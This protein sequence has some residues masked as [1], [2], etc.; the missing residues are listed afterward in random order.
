MKKFVSLFVALAIVLSLFAGVGARTA[1]AAVTPGDVDS[2]GI[3]DMIDALL[4]ARAAVHITTL[5]GDAL[6]AADVNADGTVDMVDVLLI[7]RIAVTPVTTVTVTVGS[8]T[9]SLLV[10][11]TGTIVGTPVPADAAI[12]YASSDVAIATV[13]ATTGVVT[14][15]AAGTAT[16]TVTG[17]KT[18][19]TNGTATVAVTVAPAAVTLSTVSAVNGTVT[20]TLSGT[21]AIAPAIADFA[22]TQAINGAAATAVT[23]TAISTTGAVVTLTVPL[24]AVGAAGTVDQSVV[25]S[26]SYKSGTAVNASAFTVVSLF[27][28]SS[29]ST[30]GLTQVQIVFNRALDPTSAVLKTNY[31]YGVAGSE[32]ALAVGDT[33][34]LSADAK[35]VTLTLA[36]PELQQAIKSIKVLTTL[37]DA[38][39]TALAASVT[40]SVTFFDTTT[41]T[42]LSAEVSGPQSIKV[43][44]SEPITSSAITTTSNFVVDGGTY[45]VAS[46]AA[47]GTSAVIVSLGL[48]LPAG[49]HT[50]TVNN[51]GTN[52]NPAIKDYAGFF[53]PKTTLNFT[54]AAD[55]AAPTVSLVSAGQNSVIIEFSKPIVTNRSNLRVYHTYANASYLASTTTWDADNQTVTL[56]FTTY[57]P[58]G[59]A[60][61]FVQN[62]DTVAANQ[63]KDSWGNA[64]V[65]AT[66]TAT[67]TSDTTAPTVTSAAFNAVSGKIDVTFSEA[68]TATS[69]S[70][71]NDAL[72]PANYVLKLGTTTIAVTGVTY[73]A[74]VASLTA[75]L[76]GG[77]YT[78]VVKNVEDI[79][80]VPNIMVDSA[81][82][83][84]AVADT[85][86]PYT[87][88]ND[89]TTAGVLLYA[90]DGTSEV[91]KVYFSE[92]MNATDLADVTKYTATVG[93]V[94]GTNPDTAVAAADGKSVTLTFSGAATL[95]FIGQ[96]RDLSG[97]RMA[98]LS[99]SLTI[100]AV[101]APTITKAW[102]TSFHTIDLYCDTVITGAQVGDFGIDLTGNNTAWEAPAG[103]STSLVS[104]K[105]VI[106]LTTTGALAGTAWD[107][108]TVPHVRT[109]ATVAAAAIGAEDA[110]G[111]KLNIPTFAT[112]D[113]IAPTH[114]TSESTLRAAVAVAG[115]QIILDND[116][117]I[118]AGTSLDITGA[119]VRIVGYNHSLSFTNPTLIYALRI[120]AADVTISNTTISALSTAA[121]FYGIDAEGASNFTLSGSTVVLTPAGASV[122]DAAL[123]TDGMTGTT[124]LTLTDNTFKGCVILG[125]SA[126][127]M[128]GSAT[129]NFF[130]YSAR[131]GTIDGAGF[132]VATAGTYTGA[133]I[134]PTALV[135][136]LNA[137]AQGNSITGNG[138]TTPATF[139]VAKEF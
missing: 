63:L 52:A 61:I 111:N 4:A 30:I 3:V 115:N 54:Y 103:I 81:T 93:G 78:L 73:A 34:T 116:I 135:T 79:A 65:N 113:K 109:I 70:G 134:T 87:V 85:V 48:A 32:A 91:F 49:A 40:K 55:A 64:F 106:T 8:P 10:G 37:I 42:A 104:G 62:A 107:T 26:V 122:Q 38:G 9:M 128:I 121:T 68:V 2:N 137:V 118:T 25:D 108:G 139:V 74:K 90:L 129:G 36:T 31:N 138:G 76:T 77:D 97:N 44:F 50:I 131:T 66:L 84:V 102:A 43:T 16:I 67:V 53:V 12:T 98:A 41:P 92:A 89:G 125:S 19:Y 110:Y 6:A 105:T 17:A 23:P 117:T 20:A 100:Q 18:G 95:P 13:D 11:A 24:V 28:V 133:A 29:A 136:Y 88:N 46:V 27:G 5:T 35:T 82:L 22:V 57:L 51:I 101:V 1:K 130:D 132:I 56:A 114:V 7:A 75:T 126:S 14:A 127:S 59:T 72:N 33:L 94:A 99:T 71:A 119:S 39:G 45:S 124:G 83:T 60:T 58:L 69:A 47:S 112:V 21:P 123:Y 96:L 15:V 120:S 86:K 80:L